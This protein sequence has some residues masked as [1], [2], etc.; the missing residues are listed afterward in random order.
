MYLMYLLVITYNKHIQRQ[1]IKIKKIK[2]EVLSWDEP[3][4]SPTDCYKNCN[5]V[6]YHEV[7]SFEP[8]VAIQRT[9]TENYLEELFTL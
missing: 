4:N 5:A 6:S 7:W 8:T 9:E 3:W 1:M 2:K